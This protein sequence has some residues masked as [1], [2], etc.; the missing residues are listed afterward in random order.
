[1]TRVIGSY[2]G[3]YVSKS[4]C[5]NR[6]SYLLGPLELSEAPRYQ[7]YLLGSVELSEAPHPELSNKLTIDAET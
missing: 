2:S 5:T 4:V 1:M 7:S 3:N 6:E